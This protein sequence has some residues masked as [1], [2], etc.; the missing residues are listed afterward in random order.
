MVR[1]LRVVL[2]MMVGGLGG[3]STPLAKPT[4][5]DGVMLLEEELDMP[6]DLT[7][8]A[9]QYVMAPPALE[10]EQSRSNAVAFARGSGASHVLHRRVAY[11][12]TGLMLV[13]VYEAFADPTAQRAPVRAASPDDV[14][15]VRS[16]RAV[17]GLRKLDTWRMPAGNSDG[18]NVSTAR[19]WAFPKGADVVRFRHADAWPFGLELVLEAYQYPR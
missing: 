10:L 12:Y 14:L 19:N 9:S 4:M 8:V 18:I 7:L 16:D 1:L 6:A 5:V 3:C 11:S 2:M 15:V 13:V 17:A